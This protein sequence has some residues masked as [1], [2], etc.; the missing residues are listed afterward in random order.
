MCQVG[1]LFKS[2]CFPISP[3]AE[4]KGGAG[5]GFY[6]Q[7]MEEGASGKLQLWTGKNLGASK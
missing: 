3:D 6:K 4:I 2:Y 5:W 7:E 1:N